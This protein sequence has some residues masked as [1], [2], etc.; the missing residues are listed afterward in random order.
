MKTLHE[1]CGGK[2]IKW[3]RRRRRCV[4]C[5]TT[6][7]AWKRKRGRKRKRFPSMLAY[8]YLKREIPSLSVI[9]HKH[10]LSKDHY[11]RTL[12]RS[13]Q[14][15]LRHTS[16]PTI[17]SGVPLV[18]IADAMMARVEKRIFTFYL[19]LLRPHKK[20]RAIITAP[21]V[22]EGKESWQGW[23]EAFARLS[24][25]ALKAVVALVCDGH[26]GLYSVA[27]HKKWLIQFCVFHIIAKI[28]GRRS[29]WT[30]SRHRQEGE[31]FYQLLGV[32]LTNTSETKVLT[33]LDGLANIREHTHSPQLKRY[34]SGLIRNRR[35]YRT[36]LLYPDL[37][38]PRTS[39]SAEALI[40]I[41]RTLLNRAHGFRTVPALTRWVYALLKLKQTIACNGFSPT[42]LTR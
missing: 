28:Q 14:H 16:W 17:P 5:S 30:R 22:K 41:I 11:Q 40:Q 31:R 25:K 2:V 34:L 8:K 29:R 32:V 36:Y 39:N 6:W 4:S 37:H 27:L 9:A 42:E 23:Q 18:A 1:N 7:S 13:L 12:Q 35:L 33:A 26:R 15:F 10:H 3:S 21:Y 20:H 19:I 24:P 38:L